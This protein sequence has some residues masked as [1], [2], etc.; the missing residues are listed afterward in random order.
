MMISE[1]YR[2]RLIDESTQLDQM[3]GAFSEFEKLVIE[4]INDKNPQSVLEII[5][6]LGKT[7]KQHPSSI[8]YK[9]Q[10]KIC[11][12]LFMYLGA[13]DVEEMVEGVQEV[14]SLSLDILLNQLDDLIG[15]REVKKQ[16]RE[17]ISFNQI[18]QLREKRGLKKS[19]K[20]LHMAFLGNP[21]TAKT[22]V[23]RIVG[24]MY[25]S[26]GLIS[27]GHFIEAS[28]SDLIAEYQG[29][30][31]IKVKRLVNRA[32]G[33]VLFIDEAYSITENEHSDSY[34][35]ESLTE[36]TKALEDYRDDLVV[37]VAG[38][39]D[40][41]DQFFDSN[42][43]LKSRFNTF[44]NFDDY[45]L[46]EL[47]NIFKFECKKNDYITD[48]SVL[49]KVKEYLQKEKSDNHFANGRSVRNLFDAVIMN[50]SVRLSKE[51]GEVSNG[52]LQM[53]TLSDIPTNK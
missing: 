14:S 28:R 25:K 8:I 44:I 16:V 45:S 48:K 34:G 52:M 31:A 9:K 29:Q 21:G 19:H 38:Y 49:S 1:K 53:I 4:I 24:K 30:T 20:T 32:R 11:E 5:Q 39:T 36:L 3:L 23:A 43:G 47:V 46:N 37:I 10:E 6:K 27:K 22:T 33:G 18:Q 41:M 40:L 12:L 13:S 17:L 50:Q 51:T 15:L 2:K 42:P 26:I 35:R 7:A